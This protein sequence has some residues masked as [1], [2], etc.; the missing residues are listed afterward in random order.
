MDLHA[1]MI[2]ERDT[3]LSYVCWLVV[4]KQAGTSWWDLAVV[5]RQ[6]LCGQIPI[7]QIGKKEWSFDL[8]NITDAY[9][10]YR[11]VTPN[12]AA[13]TYICLPISQQHQTPTGCI[14]GG[15]LLCR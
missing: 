13:Y 9:R 14:F 4:N 2:L 15:L 8:C 3:F 12:Q 7:S 10:I 6:G 1:K 5:E 11:S